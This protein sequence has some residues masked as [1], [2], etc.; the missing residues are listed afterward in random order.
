MNVPNLNSK[1]AKVNGKRKIVA[2]QARKNALQTAK[3]PSKE[4]SPYSALKVLY[5]GVFGDDFAAV[6]LG[7][8]LCQ[9]TPPEKANSEGVIK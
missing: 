4:N 9:P 3:K 7:E 2:L 1:V 8:D 5:M 6:D